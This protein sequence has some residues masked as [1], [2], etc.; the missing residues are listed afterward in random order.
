M[1]R[2]RRGLKGRLARSYLAVIALSL[3]VMLALYGTVTGLLLF[4]GRASQTGFTELLAV[5]IAS[6]TAAAAQAGE[7]GEVDAAIGRV[8]S[9]G[10]KPQAGFV[11]RLSFDWDSSFY[12]VFIVDR[13]FRVIHAYREASP[14]P[15]F[16]SG[17]RRGL[18]D[19][20]LGG[21][22]GAAE[23]LPAE[24]R[25]IAAHPMADREGASAAIVWIQSPASGGFLNDFTVVL[26]AGGVFLLFACVIS[27][28]LAAGVASRFARLISDPLRELAGASRRIAEGCLEPPPVFRTGD[29][30]ERLSTDM[31]L[32]T[33]AL[34]KT[35]DGLAAERETVQ[36]LLKARQDLTANVSHDL[37]TPL[38]SLL[39]HVEAM[40]EK[41]LVRTE[42]GRRYLE[43]VRS[44]AERLETLI[45]DLFL[46]TRL[47][48]AELPVQ[49]GP[50]S[51]QE[52][53][54]GLCAGFRERS[55]R[56]KRITVA[57]EVSPDCPPVLADRQRLE[58][59][60]ANLIS[61]AV[62]YTPDGGIIRVAAHPEAAGVRLE[63]QD[64]GMGISREDLPQVFERFY[65]GEKS[66]SRSDGGS[67]LGLSIAKELVE[68]QG[69]RITVD[70]IHGEGTTFTI[71]L[72]A[73]PR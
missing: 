68:R 24:H 45:E 26:G 3:G 57:S 70:S 61:N 21:R 19:R 15:D 34:S 62:R 67:G 53:V 18:A 29:E 8:L 36:A 42:E 58:Q 27:G 55:M 73:A 63:V 38:A 22:A 13:S 32:M 16:T 25:S 50:T 4:A 5:E 12:D 20:A 49:L 69:G 6:Q 17:A 48:N 37:R 33:S 46:L 52:L 39:S 71:R 56:D 59:V 72:N 51:L 28:F 35:M 7:W 10:V 65:K 64:T 41:E 14:I 54:P 31:S 60:L 11:F 47:E 43:I 30:I 23:Y 9:A 2:S 1:G 66:R 40:E 44:E